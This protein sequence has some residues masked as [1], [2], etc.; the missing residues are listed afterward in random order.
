MLRKFF[1]KKLQG[2]SQPIFPK[3]SFS[4]FK[5]TLP[6]GWGLATIN[7]GYDHYPN[8]QYYPCHVLVELEVVNPNENGHPTDEEASRLYTIEEEIVGL[9]KQYQTVH[10]I[11][12]VTRKGF[13]DL[14]IYTDEPKTP[15]EQIFGYCDSITKERAINFEMSNDKTWKNVSTFLDN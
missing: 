9:L 1:S 8:K 14:L 5:L 12:R 6:D 11:G 15:E 10:V 7:K 2:P 13:R 3:E 4:I